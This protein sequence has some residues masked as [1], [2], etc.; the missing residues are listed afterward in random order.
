MKGG[1]LLLV[2]VMVGALAGCAIDSTLYPMNESAQNLG[3]LHATVHESGL[4]R[5]TII[6]K[7]PSG[8]I[9]TGQYSVVSGS[10]Y[11][12]GSGFA[13]IGGV[14]GSG[15]GSSETLPGTRV[16][17]AALQG[18]DGTTAQCK[19]YVSSWGHGAGLC[20]FSDGAK[21]RMMF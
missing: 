20:E 5:G 18:N 4:G 3:V 9:L 15:M 1:K 13:S 2:V 19:F 8:E 10:S 14:A 17:Y 21:Y 11:T 6:C 7:L 12:F 16:G